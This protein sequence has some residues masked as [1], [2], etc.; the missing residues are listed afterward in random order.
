MIK[1][2]T[3]ALGVAL[4]AASFGSPAAAQSWPT[5]PVS[6]IVAFGPGG[7]TDQ[8]ARMVAD[9][10]SERIGQPVVV[11]NRPGAGGTIGADAAAKA[12]PD[13][14]TLYMM[15]NGHAVA[16]AM[17]ASLPYDPVGD[18]QGVSLV[19]T[20]PLVVVARQDFPANSLEELIALANERP[21][22]LNYATIGVGSSQH[23]AGALLA[24]TVGIDMFHIPYQNTPEALAAVLSGEVDLLVEVLAPMMGQISGADIKALVLTSAERHP[25]LPDVATVAEAGFPQYDV[26]TWYGLA[27]PAGVSAEIVAQAHAAVSEVLADSTMAVRV[28]G[29]GFVIEG[30]APDAFTAH[31]AAEAARWSAVREANGIEQR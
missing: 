7:G 11:E 21:G 30:S 27:Y 19:A 3:A 20:M 25:R 2:V 17:Y 14:Q 6:I 18:F 9:P 31:F 26:A 16:A 29:S 10:L 15:A 24:E 4:V 5:G 13:G 12:A 28:L 22:E 1:S 23:F 8:L